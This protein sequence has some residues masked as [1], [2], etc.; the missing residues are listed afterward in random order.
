MPKSAYNDFLEK[1]N[2]LIDE[3]RE[4][5]VLQ[6]ANQLQIQDGKKKD[7]G[8]YVTAAQAAV[9]SYWDNLDKKLSI[10]GGKNTIS[11]INNWLRNEYR[12][13]CSQSKIISAIQADEIDTEMIT[14]LNKICG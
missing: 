14:L 9:S 5:T 7:L 10:V 12:V 1:L 13:P 3:Q 8:S 6:Y 11:L 4:P 2:S